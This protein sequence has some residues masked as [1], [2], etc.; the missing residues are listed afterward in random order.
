MPALSTNPLFQ[1]APAAAP[2]SW[3]SLLTN[4]KM[5]D[6]PD[7]NEPGTMPDEDLAIESPEFE[8]DDDFDMAP[9]PRPDENLMDDEL[10]TPANTPRAPR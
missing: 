9:H 4:K 6:D 8:D 1:V 2:L 7:A 10:I 5:P 3:E